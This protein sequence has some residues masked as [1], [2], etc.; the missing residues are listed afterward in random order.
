MGI[1][2]RNKDAGGGNSAPS[3][4]ASR[5]WGETLE[6]LKSHEG[7][8][9]LDFG[10]TSPAN[11]NF[12]TSLGHS[13]YMANV[14]EDATKPEWQK[15]GEDGKTVFDH[16]RFAEANFDFS[17]KEFDAVLLWDTADYLPPSSVPLLFE[18]LAKKLHPGGRL[19][20]FSHGKMDGPGTQYVRFHVTDKPEVLT[21]PTGNFPILGLYQPRQIEQF[22]DGYADRRF[23]L[24][25]DNTREVIAVR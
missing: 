25:K 11:I 6:Y 4:R 22:L 2:S 18:R 7:L 17:G 3:T 13:V 16:E 23:L 12:L 8:R 14:V 19:L 9:V 21:V 20:A 24:G 10:D 1:F 15:V 5:G